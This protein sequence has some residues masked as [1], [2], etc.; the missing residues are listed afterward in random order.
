MCSVNRDWVALALSL[1]LAVVACSRLVCAYACIL[2][3]SC[4]MKCFD[5]LLFF[6]IQV[7]KWPLS[8]TSIHTDQTL[9]IL[10]ESWLVSRWAATNSNYLQFGSIDFKSQF[11]THTVNRK[12]NMKIILT[13]EL[14]RWTTNY[15]RF[16]CCHFSPSIKFDS[17]FLSWF[18][19]ISFCSFHKYL[20]C[21]LYQMSL[22]MKT[23]S[24]NEWWSFNQSGR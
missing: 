4:Y 5:F 7:D 20:F 11:D 13:N 23:A 17:K 3:M 6:L 15:Q 24:S 19:E 2:Y 16:E 21:L 14:L 10:D 8:Y 18:N 1:T 12:K 22:W 9:W